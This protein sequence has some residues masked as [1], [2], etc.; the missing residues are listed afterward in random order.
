MVIFS[1]FSDT[2]CLTDLIQAY[3]SFRT[4]TEYLAAIIPTKW[5]LSR[6]GSK[7]EQHFLN[8][9]KFYGGLK[10]APSSPKAGRKN[11]LNHRLLSRR[12]SD[13]AEI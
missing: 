8:L 6:S 4:T 2:Q 12:L 11:L 9:K 10:A 5:L 7:I 1:V 13:F 3:T